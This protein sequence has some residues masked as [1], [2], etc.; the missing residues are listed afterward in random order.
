MNF[1]EF[2]DLISIQFW[3]DDIEGY[4]ICSGCKVL[5]DKPAKEHH[6]SINCPFSKLKTWQK[7]RTS[8]IKENFELYQ[9]FCQAQAIDTEMIRASTNGDKPVPL[10]WYHKNIRNLAK[11]TLRIS[12]E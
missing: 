3:W 1:K 2:F 7:I 11:L 12:E 9:K 4:W 8:V 10:H 5:F 6:S